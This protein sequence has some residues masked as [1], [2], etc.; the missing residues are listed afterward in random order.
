MR[1]G[2]DVGG[3]NTDAVMLAGRQIVAKV[4]S[5]T[6]ADVSGGIRAAIGTLLAESQTRASDVDAVMIGT[7][8]FTNAF[9]QARDLRKVAALRIGFPAARGVPPF[10]D[11]P[12]RL[13]M[14]TFGH[15]AM[16]AGGYQF[17]GRA[18]APLAELEIAKAARDIARLGLTEVAITGVFSQLNA[19]QEERA[20]EI[21]RGE[22]PDANI[23]LS[24]EV[25]R[26]GLLERENAAIMNAALRPLA[27]DVGDAFA[28]ALGELDIRC[29]FFVSQND[30]TLMTASHMQRFPVLTF[31]AGPTNSLRGA[32]YLTGMSDALVADVGGT[33]TDIGVLVSGFPRQS[34]LHVD[35]G[36]VRTN[37]RMPDV[38]SIGLGGGSRVR[39][40]AGPGGG[41]EIGP[42]SVGFRL[43]ED[44][45]IFGGN[46][47][48]ASDIAVAAGR[49]RFGDPSRVAHL[50]AAQIAEAVA[51]MRAL[52]EEGLDRMKTSAAELPLIL[53]GG[54]AVL[55]NEP[56]AGVSETIVPDGAGV[57]NAVGAAI[58]Q[59]SGSVDRIYNFQEIGREAARE[60]AQARA[61]ARAA[62][63]GADPA[64]I[65]VVDL[66]DLPLQYLPGGAARV[67]CRAIG[68]LASMEVARG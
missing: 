27:I 53:V 67:V 54:G 52:V 17:D 62:E 4:K 42:D 32:A 61:I 24:S 6:S 35:V 43:H 46:E 12:E 33:T 47:L 63:A 13:R 48:T 55:I 56:L 44:A 5:P 1:I 49:A 64:T 66:E 10:A 21:V 59:V 20:G 11:W 3:T 9:V 18:I 50:G 2:V 30:G 25:G 58:G 23:T 15:I 36:G 26:T 31:A 38:L 60:D 65:S 57:A 45:M 51:R 34:S 29:P 39:F 41:T 22:I 28:R 19:E 68:D 8:H 16:V 14:A 37:F 7:T 40:G